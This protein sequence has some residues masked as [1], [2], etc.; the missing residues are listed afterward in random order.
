MERPGA[1]GHSNFWGRAAINVLRAIH[2]QQ[3]ADDAARL[4]IEPRRPSCNT[5]RSKPTGSCGFTT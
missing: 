3:E 1:G 5:V 2:S 4:A